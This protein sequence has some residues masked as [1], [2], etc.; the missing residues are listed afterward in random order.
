MTKEEILKKL[1]DLQSKRENLRLEQSKVENEIAELMNIRPHK[2]SNF[3]VRLFKKIFNIGR[4][5]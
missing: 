5:K 1:Q 2:K 3:F 4:K